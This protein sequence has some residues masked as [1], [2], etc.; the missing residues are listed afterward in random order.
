MKKAVSCCEKLNIKNTKNNNVGALSATIRTPA[1]VRKLGYLHCL[2][3]WWLFGRHKP[4]TKNEVTS[5]YFFGER[6]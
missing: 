3:A 6:L 2:N 1:T 4:D 5:H